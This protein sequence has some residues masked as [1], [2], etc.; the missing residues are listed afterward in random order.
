MAGPKADGRG[1]IISP[2]SVM[3][4]L[5]MRPGHQLDCTRTADDRFEL[6]AATQDVRLLRGIVKA[7]RTV[8]L[9]EMKNAVRV[10]AT[11]S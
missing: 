2:A 7:E 6:L 10:R 4:R 5:S 1:Q 9:A 3:E 11:E 8:S